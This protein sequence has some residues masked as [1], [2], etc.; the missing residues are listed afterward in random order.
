ME[1]ATAHVTGARPRRWLA[2]ARH[3]PHHIG[4]HRRMHPERYAE[5]LAMSPNDLVQLDG[6]KGEGG[7]QILRTALG[8]SLITGRP[9]KISRIRA[10]RENPGLRPQHLAAGE[11]AAILS[12]ADVVGASVGARDLIF[13]PG[14][15]DP[16][17][18]EY[19]I[20]TAGST[21]L[22]LQ[23]LHLPIALNAQRGVRVGITGGTFNHKAPSYPFLEST[24]R[25][26]MAS[27]G[28]HVSMSMPAAGFYPKGGGDL[29]A[30]IEPG[31]PRPLT[32]VNRGRLLSIRGQAG[33]CRLQRD[34]IP[35]RMRRQAEA[36]LGELTPNIRIESVEWP[37]SSPGAAIALTAEYEGGGATFLGLGERGKLAETVADEAAGDLLEHHDGGG[38]ID[39]YSADQILLPLVFAPGRSE[40][41]VSE[42]TEHLRTNVRTIS[43]FVDRSI[44]VIEPEVE[45]EP[46]R[47]IVE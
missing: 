4:P 28:L 25:R 15:I 30:W 16:R 7:G 45:G 14:P 34:E 38:A 21:A 17:D 11:A 44:I 10:N 8:L 1:R 43:A 6:S 37:G 33:V 27:I 13:R 42:V 29:E 24:W 9:F 41:T 36:I 18:I 23:T 19:A 32:R 46:G 2:H 12:A 22:V 47:V 26:H 3:E 20:G 35:D 39:A 31:S 40:Y 5:P